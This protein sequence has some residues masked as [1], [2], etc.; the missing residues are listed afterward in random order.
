MTVKTRRACVI[1]SLSGVEPAAT[2]VGPCDDR[3][4]FDDAFV[5][6][7]QLALDF[8]H[9]LDVEPALR[10]ERA[11]RPVEQVAPRL[12]RRVPGLAPVP[13]DPR[14]QALRARLRVTQGVIAA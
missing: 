14:I 5:A 7:G 13:R 3:V 9:S 10:A 12:P 2:P 4:Q 11:R 6:D 8:N 1:G